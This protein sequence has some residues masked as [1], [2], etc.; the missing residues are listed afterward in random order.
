MMD[1][2]ACVT[3]QSDAAGVCRTSVVGY[4]NRRAEAF[5]P[6]DEPTANVML[7]TGRRG[8]QAVYDRHPGSRKMAVMQG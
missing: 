7:A 2:R 4:G 8:G 5:Y 1:A 6:A 3:H